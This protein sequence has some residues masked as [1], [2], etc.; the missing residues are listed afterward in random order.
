M[1]SNLKDNPINH[2]PEILVILFLFVAPIVLFV[3]GL[4]WVGA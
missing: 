2:K 4:I 1:N 3:A